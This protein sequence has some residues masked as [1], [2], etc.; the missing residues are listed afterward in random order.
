MAPRARNWNMEAGRRDNWDADELGGGRERE[1]GWT[2]RVRALKR[3]TTLGIYVL[4][5]EF[6]PLNREE[7]REGR[8]RDLDVGRVALDGGRKR[9]NIS[10]EPAAGVREI[11]TP[12]VK[13]RGFSIDLV[14]QNRVGCKN[15]GFRGDNH[16]PAPS[17]FPHQNSMYN[18]FCRADADRLE[19]AV[20]AAKQ[21]ESRCPPSSAFRSPLWRSERCGKRACGCTPLL[22]VAPYDDRLTSITGPTRLSQARRTEL[23]ENDIHRSQFGLTRIRG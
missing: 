20:V 19:W 23:E 22:V 17:G 2:K 1:K 11:P 14:D 16:S 6:H 21:G 3:P 10:G 7:P 5:K 9:E 8:K 12:L 18:T 13:P 15:R 4:R